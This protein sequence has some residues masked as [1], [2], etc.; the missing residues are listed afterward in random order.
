MVEQASVIERALKLA[1]TGLFSSVNQLQ[2]RLRREGFENV[3]QH[4]HGR[5]T[6]EMI[7]KAIKDASQDST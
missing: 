5:A 6:R 2:R 1:S 4:L 7:L 3:D